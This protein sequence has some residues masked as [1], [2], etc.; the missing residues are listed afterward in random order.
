[1][2]L[3]NQLFNESFKKIHKLRT[4]FTT[5][6]QSDK[7]STKGTHWIRAAAELTSD[8]QNMICLKN[9]VFFS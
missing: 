1:M 2:A 4:N 8:L 5:L 3:T 7:P 6:N 9:K